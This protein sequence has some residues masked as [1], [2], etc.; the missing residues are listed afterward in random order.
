V[1]T[2]HVPLPISPL[3]YKVQ[4]RVYKRGVNEK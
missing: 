3:Y 1:A 4:N 2:G